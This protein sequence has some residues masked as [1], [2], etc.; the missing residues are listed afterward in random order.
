MKGKVYV[1]PV[2]GRPPDPPM[3]LACRGP[4]FCDTAIAYCVNQFIST[5]AKP[6]PSLYKRGRGQSRTLSI[7]EQSHIREC[8][9]DE[10]WC[11][12]ID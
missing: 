12:Y 8:V 7:F 3:S 10:G 11:F 1:Q 4:K 6:N 9:Y 5:W 2:C